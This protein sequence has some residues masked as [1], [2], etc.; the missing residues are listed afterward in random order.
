MREDATTSRWRQAFAECAPTLEALGRAGDEELRLA[1]RAWWVVCM[2]GRVQ[3]CKSTHATW[4]SEASHE[5]GEQLR[6]SDTEA[7]VSLASWPPLAQCVLDCGR[8]VGVDVSRTL[9]AVEEEGIKQQA[10]AKWHRAVAEGGPLRSR[11]QQELLKN[12]LA[13]SRAAME[14]DELRVCQI[15]TYA[16]A[17]RLEACQSHA[18]EFAVAAGMRNANQPLVGYDEERW[19]PNVPAWQDMELCLMSEAERASADCDR[20]WR[21]TV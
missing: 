16:L 17:S 11:L 9:A 19:D 7:A 3:E 18:R 20:L 2:G 5:L 6:P 10:G 14:V 12:R 15:W 8:A 1:T 4:K 21:G 13:P